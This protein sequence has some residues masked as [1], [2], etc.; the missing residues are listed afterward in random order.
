MNLVVNEHNLIAFIPELSLMVASFCGILML[1]TLRLVSRSQSSLLSEQWATG[2]LLQLTLTP[3]QF[4]SLESSKSLEEALSVLSTYHYHNANYGMRCILEVLDDDLLDAAG[5]AHLPILLEAFGRHGGTLPFND[6]V[7]RICRKKALKVLSRTT[8]K[9]LESARAPKA[10]RVLESYLYINATKV[11]GHLLR[12]ATEWR[13]MPDLRRQRNLLRVV[14]LLI[15][16]GAQLE[17][18][19]PLHRDQAYQLLLIIEDKKRM[20]RT[21]ASLMV[22]GL[23]ACAHHYIRGSILRGIDDLYPTLMG[24]EQLREYIGAGPFTDP[25][26]ETKVKA[27]LD[28]FGCA[29]QDSEGT[30]MAMKIIRSSNFSGKF[31]EKALGLILGHPSWDP[32]VMA[33]VDRQG[34][35]ILRETF[36]FFK[37]VFWDVFRLLV[38]AGAN[39]FH[40]VASKG[41]KSY[42]MM[43]AKYV[44]NP[45]KLVN[46]LVRCPDLTASLN[47]QDSKGFTLL[48]FMLRNKACTTGC[49]E[50]LLEVGAELD[51]ASKKIRWARRALHRLGYDIVNN[52]LVKSS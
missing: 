18:L 13:G 37:D 14:K 39:P 6:E 48:H 30:T 47:Q 45:I 5:Q 9:V 4:Q 15:K 11:A 19:P 42:A 51:L 23:Q 8:I 34:H 1:P 3:S 21:V 38:E 33:L 12:K 31:M 22:A 25:F 44:M 40:Q 27:L 32:S 49:L 28:V 7:D 36:T 46:L 10:R 43:A 41:N 2:C 50:R 20:W 29:H 26:A 17:M 52:E 24:D 16:H 35:T